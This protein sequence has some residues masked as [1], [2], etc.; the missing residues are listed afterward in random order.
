MNNSSDSD[1][2]QEIN[3]AANI[4]CLSILPEKS[5]KRYEQTYKNFKDWCSAKQ[6]FTTSEKVML[7]YLM[8]RA[9]IL[10]PPSLWCEYSMLKSTIYLNENIDISSYKKLQA[11]LKRK[12][13][14]HRP[15][16][17]SVFTREDIVKFLVEAPDD[18]YLMKKVS[19]NGYNK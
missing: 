15:K 10:Q 2:P 19:Q 16:K 13:I 8:Q 3:E 18:I 1:T 5:K 12:N 17:S 7:A 11:F 14:G 9:D 4:A 6:V